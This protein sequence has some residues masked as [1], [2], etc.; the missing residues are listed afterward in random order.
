MNDPSQHRAVIL[1]ITTP[2]DGP[3]DPPIKISG[4]LV[5]CLEMDDDDRTLLFD[6]EGLCLGDAT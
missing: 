4:R 6:I 3:D 2:D 1:S 5:R